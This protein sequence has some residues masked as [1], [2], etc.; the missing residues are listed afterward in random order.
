MKIL[1]I[2]KKHGVLPPSH[3]I[4]W[5]SNRP[6]E[7]WC[8]Y[9]VNNMMDKFCGRLIKVKYEEDDDKSIDQETEEKI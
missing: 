1:H 9:C 6:D 7:R 5:T 2:C 3:R 8:L 4:M